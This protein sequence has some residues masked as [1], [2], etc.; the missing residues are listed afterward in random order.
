MY[1][2]YYMYSVI[3]C[4]ILCGGPEKGRWYLQA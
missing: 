2:D 1:S 4:D 3:L